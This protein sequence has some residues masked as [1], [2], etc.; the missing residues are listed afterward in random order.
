MESYTTPL[1]SVPPH[2]N[3]EQNFFEHIGNFPTQLKSLRI[4]LVN[5]LNWT[6]LNA[7]CQKCGGEIERQT[8][9]V[10]CRSYTQQATVHFWQTKDAAA[11]K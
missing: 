9:S 1:H 4:C 6:H 3:A 10:H 11:T 7:A 8:F 5:F 2:R